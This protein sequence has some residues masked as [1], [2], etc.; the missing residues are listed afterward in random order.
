VRCEVEA[1][2]AV[3][4]LLDVITASDAATLRLRNMIGPGELPCSS[5]TWQP[6][7]SGDYPL[8]LRTLRGLVAPQLRDD[9]RRRAVGFACHVEA[10]GVGPS[11]GMKAVGTQAGGYGDRD[12]AHGA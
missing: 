1:V 2:G 9:G 8:A 4:G 3:E 11:M 7:D 12:R 10:T 6:Y 5:R